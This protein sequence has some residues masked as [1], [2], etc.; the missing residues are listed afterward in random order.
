MSTGVSV[1]F[2]PDRRHLLVDALRPPPGTR[3][4]A[5]VGTT[6]SLDLQALLIAPLSFALFDARIGETGQTTDPLALMESV[7]R[8]AG[9]IDVFYQAGQVAIPPRDLSILALLEDSV[10]PTVAPRPGFIF[11]PKIWVLKYVGDGDASYRLL[12]L[13]RNLTFDRSWDLVVGL[14]GSLADATP[15]RRAQNRP[16]ADFLISLPAQTSRPMDAERHERVRRL[17]AEILDVEWALPDGFSRVQFL[18]SGIAG[19]EHSWPERSDRALVI[20]P[21]LTPERLQWMAER[22]NPVF[23]VS[24]AESL[25][26]LEMSLL[27]R[28]EK[29]FILADVVEH[30]GLAEEEA[31]ADASVE[32]EGEVPPPDPSV[33]V[34]EELAERPGH[35]GAGLHAK[36]LAVDQG[37]YAELRIGS[38]NATTA[39]WEGNVEFDV[40]LVGAKK[41][42]GVDALLGWDRPGD[43]L[44]SLLTEYRRASHEPLKETSEEAELRQLEALSREIAAIPL[45]VAVRAEDAY[46][47]LTISSEPPL[48]LADG[49][50]VRCWP[51]SRTRDDGRLQTPGV[52]VDYTTGG[53]SLQGITS[54]VIFELSAV[55]GGQTVVIVSNAQMEGAPDDRAE[56]LLAEQLQSKRDVLRYLLLLLADLGDGGALQ[57]LQAM[58]ASSDSQ[59]AGDWQ[60][61]VPLLETMVRALARRPEALDPINRLITDLERSEAGR[62]LIP[63]GLREIWP[64]IWEARNQST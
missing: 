62:R 40:A 34:R 50:E 17:A 8:H 56:R 48:P 45:K 60:P 41:R 35:A 23:L 11:H 61:S 44:M 16:L 5:A 25:D 21:F 36:A 4:D 58:F 37:W 20:S 18:P 27:E 10:H 38:T 26:R 47:R 6:F 12:V 49:V 7:R 24:R 51:A 19:Y 57:Q 29:V 53:L 64:A 15:E 33:P 30:L 55:A 31:N 22:T 46:Y 32:E 42:T 54:F 28:F 14:D 13:T 1:L 63:D 59:P 43:S 2:D 9:H 3:L 52:P 39:G